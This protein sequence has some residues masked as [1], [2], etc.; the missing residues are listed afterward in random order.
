MKTRKVRYKEILFNVEGI[1]TDDDKVKEIMNRY[2][3]GKTAEENETNRSKRIDLMLE[4]AGN[5]S[6]DDYIMAIKKTRKHGSTVLLKRD[7]DEIYVNNYNPEWA[8]AW[9]ANHDLQ[10]VLDFFAAI[11][12]ITDYWAK[13]DEGITQHLREAATAL[14]S[15]PDQQKRCQ[16]MAN[17]FMT[18]RQMG[19]A[20]AYY[21]IFPN[22]T[23][24]YSNV[25]TIFI[26]TDKKELRSKF[27]M[28]LDESE[29]KVKEGLEVHGGRE[30]RFLEKPDIVDKFCRKIITDKNPELGALSILQFGRMFEPIRKRGGEEEFPIEDKFEGEDSDC[31]E[32]NMANNGDN[33]P[34]KDEDDRLANY[35]ITTEDKYNKIPLPNIIRLKD[36]LPGE[37]PIWRKRTFPKAARIHKK[38]KLQTH[39]D[40]SYQNLCSTRDFK[41]KMS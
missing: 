37:V 32:N 10:P 28:K 26:P 2:E 3:K 41:T 21:K 14:K 33:D 4:M 31:E 5:I 6:Y 12:Y 27:L 15:E 29:G 36:C 25:D 22:L 8:E 17:I 9:N 34:W 11:T 40:I 19:E 30:G 24:K 38:N 23:L 7:I 20:E 35:Y 1:I 13:P 18:H 16:Q 39:T